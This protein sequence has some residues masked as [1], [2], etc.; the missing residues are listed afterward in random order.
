M[1]PAIYNP[2]SCKISVV[3]RFLHVKI[4]SAT[5]IHRKLCA[6]YGQ[7]AKSIVGAFQLGV[8]FQPQSHSERLP[9]VY[10]PEELVQITTLQQ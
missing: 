2:T 8:V 1:C 4:M 7:N 3:I 9:P 10:L 5:K 6:V